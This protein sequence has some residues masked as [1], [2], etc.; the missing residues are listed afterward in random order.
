MSTDRDRD[1]SA[2]DEDP[3]P[4]EHLY[5][6]AEVADR[7]SQELHVRPALSTLR[8]A[9]ADARR[10]STPA[11]LTDGL[12]A[13]LNP[14]RHGSQTL[15]DPNAV[16]AWLAHHPRRRIRQL[17]DRLA[18]ASPEFRHRAVATARRAGLSWQQI[19]AAISRADGRRYSRQAAQQRYRFAGEDAASD[20]N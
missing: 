19:A 14:G 2:H 4:Q 8:A 17:Q 18:A 1:E 20:L 11:R 10:G 3:A 15:F 13:P 5:T 7:I 16:D 6:L 9:A 12:P